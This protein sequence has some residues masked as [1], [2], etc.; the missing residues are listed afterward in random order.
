MGLAFQKHK[1]NGEST[2]PVYIHQN[3]NSNRKLMNN[4]RTDVAKQ[5]FS[6]RNH[7]HKKD[8][9]LYKQVYEKHRSL[10]IYKKYGQRYLQRSLIQIH[11]ITVNACGKKSIHSNVT[12]FSL[13]LNSPQKK[14]RMKF[15]V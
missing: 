4:F 1:Q 3:S 15:H 5:L 6:Y 9:F 13:Q 12:S 2:S 11:V 8:I 10:T 14:K 7:Q